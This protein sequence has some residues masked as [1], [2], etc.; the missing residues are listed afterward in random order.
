MASDKPPRIR[1]GRRP[2]EE[3]RASGGGTRVTSHAV[4]GSM[5]APSDAAEDPAA[6]MADDNMEAFFSSG[7]G[8]AQHYHGSGAGGIGQEEQGEPE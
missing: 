3:I 7:T 4:T 5:A 1:T 6:D 8:A 2:G